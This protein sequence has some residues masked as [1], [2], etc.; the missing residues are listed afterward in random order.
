MYKFLARDRERGGEGWSGLRQQ[1]IGLNKL[2]I[3]YMTD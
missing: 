1:Q 2:F 3:L